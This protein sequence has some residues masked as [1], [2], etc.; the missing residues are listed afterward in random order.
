MQTAEVALLDRVVVSNRHA[1]AVACNAM[2]MQS[3][4]KQLRWLF[5]IVSSFGHRDAATLVCS[6]QMH[7]RMPD[8]RLLLAA[9]TQNNGS[10]ETT[11][12]CKALAAIAEHHVLS[13][14]L[15][16]SNAESGTARTAHDSHER[17]VAP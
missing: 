10:A 9:C 12:D 1:A 7:V 8:I 6:V 15:R 11:Q 17:Q 14:Q 4:C 16:R 3:E 2:Y 13:L 5:A